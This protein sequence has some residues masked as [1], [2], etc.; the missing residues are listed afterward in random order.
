M[1]SEEQTDD[2]YLMRQE[3]SL[4]SVT[5]RQ[6]RLFNR[7][8]NSLRTLSVRQQFQQAMA[9][10]TPPPR[11]ALLAQGDSSPVGLTDIACLHCQIKPS[12]KP[13]YPLLSKRYQLR[14]VAGFCWTS[15]GHLH[16]DIA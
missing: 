13:R 11:T 8:G 16:V 10:T 9:A 2:G 5:L 7:K 1:T 3:K 6:P 14:K 12:S 15:S 4:S